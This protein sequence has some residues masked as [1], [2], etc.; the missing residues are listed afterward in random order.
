MSS[1]I[2][3]TARSFDLLG[4]DRQIQRRVM[5]GHA[6]QLAVWS[7]V[8]VLGLKK[9]GVFGWIG[10][11]AGAFALVRELL[12]WR[13]EQPE[14]KKSSPRKPLLE[15]LLRP[16]RADRVE[17]ASAASFPASDPTSYPGN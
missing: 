1:G 5:R 2:Q 3:P 8:I 10:T 6:L 9:G 4:M 17:Q 13:D 14:W 11:G 7:G 12:S 16:G 15:R